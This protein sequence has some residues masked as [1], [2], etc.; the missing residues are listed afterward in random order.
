MHKSLRLGGSAYGNCTEGDEDIVN[1]VV[2]SW[3]FFGNPG[4]EASVAGIT[5]YVKVFL[6]GKRETVKRTYR[7]GKRIEIFGSFNSCIIQ[8][9][10]QAV[11]L[12]H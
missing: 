12:T 3:W 8:Q 1:C 6:E 11:G 4:S 5:F 9:L 7:L 10:S 2:F